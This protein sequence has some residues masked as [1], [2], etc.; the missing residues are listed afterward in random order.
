MVAPDM[1]TIYSLAS[2]ARPFR[3]PAMKLLALCL[4]AS[5]AILL[6]GCVSNEM[7]SWVGRP[8]SELIAQWGAPQRKSDDGLGGYVLTYERFIRGGPGE[9]PGGHYRTREFYVDQHGIIYRWRW[10]GL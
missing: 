7:R 2:R 9:V 8:Q 4:C 3:M 6:T 5:V 1:L 10:Q